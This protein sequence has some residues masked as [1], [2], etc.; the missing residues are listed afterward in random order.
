M[1]L[2][3]RSVVRHFVIALVLFAGICFVHAQSFRGG[4]NG[5]VTDTT[6]AAIAN[7]SVA[8]VQTDTGTTRTSVSSSAGEFSFQDLPVGSYSITISIAGFQT[9]KTDKVTVSAGTVY[10]LPVS[11]PL[12]SSSTSMEV[13]AAGIALDTTSTTQTTDIPTQVV[14]DVPMNARDFTQILQ[15]TPGFAGY[16]LGGGAGLASVNG[17]RSNEVNWQIEG[18]DNND[19]WW[20]IPA[21]N[22]G[23]V[24]GIAGIVLPLDAVEQFSFVTSGTPESG[25][26]A[27]GTVNLSIKSGTNQL[28][29]SVYYFNRNEALAAQTPF[30]PAGSPKNK[31]RNISYGFSAGGPVFRDKTFFFVSFEHQNFVIGNQTNSTEPSALYQA[32]A[33]TVL[34]Y[35][36]IPVNPLSTTLLNALWPAN[37]LTGGANSGNYFNPGTENGHSFNGIVKLDQNFSDRDQLSV[38]WYAGQGTQNAPTSSYLSPYYEEAPIHV[39]NYSIVENHTFGGR[40]ANQLFLGV[41]YFNQAFSDANHTYNPVALGLNT[42]VTDPTLSGAP[43]LIIGPPAT[44]SGLTGGNTGFDA[45]GPTAP[46]GRNDITGHIDDAL[47]YTVGAHQLRFGGEFRQARV[48]DFYKTN[49]R[50]NFV[51]DGS[52]GPWYHPAT[53]TSSNPTGTTTACDKL[54]TTN[55]G[56]PD[57]AFNTADPNASYDTNVL[58]LADFLAGCADTANIVQGNQERKVLINTFNIFAQDAWQLTPTLNFNY[59]LRYDYAG[60]ISNGS[61]NLTSFNPNIAGGFDIQGGNAS[62]LYERFFGA[63]SPRLGAAYQVGHNTV[64]RSGFGMYFNSPYILPLLNLRG[65]TNGGAI[66]VGVNPA[67]SNPVANTTATG[68]VLQ[69]GVPIFG[70]LASS[71]AGITSTVPGTVVNVF[72]VNSGFRPSYTYSYNLNVQQSLGSSLIMQLG[73]V[74]TVAHH[75]LGVQDINPTAIGSGAAQNTRPFYA[76]FPNIGNVNQLTSNLGSNYNSLQALIRT[77]RWHGVTAQGTYTLSHALDQETGLVPYLPQNSYDPGAE[78]G[79]SDFDTRHT[80]SGYISYLIPGGNAGPHLLTHGWEL[81]S[82]LNFHTGQPFTVSAST[83]TS[84]NGDSADR[85]SIVPGVDPFKGVNHSIQ[86][87]SVTWFNPA[88]FTDPAVGTFGNQR[89]NQFYN[90]GFQDIDFSVC[91][92][93]PITERINTQFRVEMFNVMNHINLA[94][95]GAP[96]TGAGATIG[97]TIGTYEGAPGIGPGEPFNVQLALKVLF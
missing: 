51:F 12:S 14:A 89:R 32:Q 54:A 55:Y 41:N 92:N 28:H 91:K 94:P 60:P 17:Q 23:G 5:T 46:S 76:K 37:A 49:S 45:I 38:K 13:E 72:S 87:G 77:S 61:T 84:G 16:S 19:L 82:V 70:S 80:F 93:T 4:I 6:G 78:Y 47:S 64:I 33:Q 25:R 1:H 30:A 2:F 10:T 65:T 67:G 63:F 52:Q 43:H 21:V 81:N 11:L 40:I 86:D 79:N 48:D 42:G 18:T 20:N 44:G 95:I 75:L 26:S 15:F 57:P 34:A 22:Q 68:A 35:Y 69:A 90:A 83:N 29:G 97:S 9:V 56:T 73:Y 74:G 59:G 36:G 3:S 50:G 53:V 8:A 58:F 88:A 62:N 71:I 24:S 7:A 39:Q 85:A 66:G 31:T 27:G 96:F